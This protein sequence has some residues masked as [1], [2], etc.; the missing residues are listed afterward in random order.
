MSRACR[1]VGLSRQAYYKRGQSE[2]HRAERD[3]KVIAWVTHARLRQPRLGTRKLHHLLR[4]PLA[5]AGIKLGRDGLFSLL[6]GARLLVV[7]QRAYHKTTHS[8]HRFRRHPNLLKAGPQQVVPTGPEQVWVADITYLATAQRFAYLSLV[9]DAYSR[10]IVGY[11]VHDTLQAEEVGQALKMALR[12]RRTRHPLIHHSD[13]GIQ[14]CSTYYQQIH[15]RHGLT[16]SMT[17]GYDCYQNALAERVNGILKGEFL[18]QRPA[19]L[20]QAA[21]M[22]EQSVKIYNHERPHQ[23]L[24]YKTPD[25]VHRAFLFT[26]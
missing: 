25:E 21:R 10:K 5:E 26:N 11:H 24:K 1:Y 6:R 9:T 22:V 23:A 13:R 17:D 2:R 8:H 19:D 20:P 7:P 16:C 18:L 14:Y 4:S 12:A 15:E 3:R